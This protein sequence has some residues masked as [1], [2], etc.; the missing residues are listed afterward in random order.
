MAANSYTSNDVA[1]QAIQLIGDNQPPVSGQAPNFDS[2]PAGIAL[3]K[4]YYPCVKTVMK[5]FEWPFTRSTLALVATPNTVPFPWGYEYY[6]P[7]NCIEVW[8]LLPPAFSDPN[9]PLP[10]NWVVANDIIANVQQRVVLSNLKNA[11]AV[12]DNAPSEGAWD[13]EFRE[14]MVRLLAS[15]LAIALGGKPDTSQSLVQTGS[16]FESLAEGRQG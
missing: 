8:Q 3:S 6:Y 2:S 14:A 5:Q 9:N 16:A 12:F 13:D 4:L 11:L 7:V 15:E 1:N 10:I